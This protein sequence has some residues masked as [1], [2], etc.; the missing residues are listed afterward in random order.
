MQDTKCRGFNVVRFSK[1]RVLESGRSVA[2]SGG[3]RTLLRQGLVQDNQVLGALPSVGIKADFPGES[4]PERAGAYKMRQPHVLGPFQLQ[5]APFPVLYYVMIHPG[6][7][8]PGVNEM[9]LPN[10]RLPTYNTELNI[11]LCCTK[12]SRFRYFVM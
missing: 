1:V 7:P 5:L 11:P 3:A 10:L 9:E 4:A 8:S 6:G 2:T 12:L